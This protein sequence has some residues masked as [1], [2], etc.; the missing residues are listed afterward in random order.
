MCSEPMHHE[1]TTTVRV[2]L[3]SLTQRKEQLLSREYDEFQRAVHGDKDVALYSAT[4]QQAGKVRTNKNPREDTTQPVVLRNDCLT[5]ER[6]D[7]TVLSDWWCKVPVY[8]PDRGRGNSIW[9][10]AIVPEKDESLLEDKGISDSELVRK[11]DN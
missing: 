3:H 9:C 7:D 1:V 4:K 10:P 6:D 11:D 5:I 8:D 2:R